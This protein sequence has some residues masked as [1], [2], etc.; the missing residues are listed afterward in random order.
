MNWIIN[1][2]VGS[3]INWLSDR[4][5]I[6]CSTW[7]STQYSWWQ[8]DI[9]LINGIIIISIN[10]IMFT[11]VGCIFGNYH[12]INAYPICI[13]MQSF[14]YVFV[15]PLVHV[16]ELM[17]IVKRRCVTW[18]VLGAIPIMQRIFS[19]DHSNILIKSQSNC[20]PD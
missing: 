11:A 8:F 20:L 10:R 3:L 1:A 6:Y 16:M 18:V 14:L 2:L 19:N 15:E 9:I 17:K 5:K 7:L 4:S 13:H 12:Q